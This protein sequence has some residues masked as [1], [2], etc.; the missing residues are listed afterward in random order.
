MQVNDYL[1]ME[2]AVE[3]GISYGYMRAYKYTDTPTPEMV[4]DAIRQSVMNEI[5]D[6]FKFQSLSA[7]DSGDSA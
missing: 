2:R 1:V 6:W 5:C 3:E 7:M 4:K